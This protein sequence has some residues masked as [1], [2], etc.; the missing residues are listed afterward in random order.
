MTENDYQILLDVIEPLAGEWLADNPQVSDEAIVSLLAQTLQESLAWKLDTEKTAEAVRNHVTRHLRQ[1]CADMPKEEA[2]RGTAVILSAAAL[3][4]FAKG[5]YSTTDLA[6]ELF[7]RAA[8]IGSKDYQRNQ[9]KLMG[10]LQEIG[11]KEHQLMCRICQDITM[12][13]QLPKG[14]ELSTPASANALNSKYSYTFQEGSKP[15][16]ISE[17][18]FSHQPQ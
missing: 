2:R 1:M 17:P 8:T 9:G 13:K 4:I 6:N 10:K 15:V 14:R 16:I 12:L 18:N 11:D 5:D 3:L 7:Y